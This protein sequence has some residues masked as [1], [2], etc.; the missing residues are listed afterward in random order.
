MVLG[1][2]FS[3][4]AVILL[5]C[6]CLSGSLESWWKAAAVMVA[7]PC[8]SFIALWIYCV[9]LDGSLF[10]LS[11]MFAMPP[12]ISSQYWLACFANALDISLRQVMLGNIH[13]E[14]I[15]RLMEH[16]LPVMRVSA[17]VVVFSFIFTILT[18]SLM[19]MLLGVVIFY[20][21]NPIGP[22]S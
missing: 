11:R 2:A 17:I 9:T 1:Y 16:N 15:S 10:G 4:F 18:S 5:L 3:I 12:V 8:I 7:W 14:A 20:Y 21:C 22:S 19:F 13:L 6:C